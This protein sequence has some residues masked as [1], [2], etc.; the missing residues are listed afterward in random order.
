MS[1]NHHKPKGANADAAARLVVASY[2][3]MASTARW[4]P[5]GR[6]DT[7]VSIRFRSW[8]SGAAPILILRRV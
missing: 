8:A 5:V 2:E 3:F 4:C 1:S 6:S 7:T